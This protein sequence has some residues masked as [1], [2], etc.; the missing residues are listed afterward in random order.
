MSILA[1]LTNIYTNMI[2]ITKQ[3][4]PVRVLRVNSISSG[5]NINAGKFVAIVKNRWKLHRFLIILFKDGI[6]KV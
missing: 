2:W 6:L 5:T 3:Q 1:Q 4:N